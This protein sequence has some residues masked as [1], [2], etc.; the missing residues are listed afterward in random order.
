MT[1]FEASSQNFPGRTEENH[2]DL[3][4]DSWSLGQDLNQGPSRYEAGVLLVL[5]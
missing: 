1:L 5:S 3:S 4:Q 2:K